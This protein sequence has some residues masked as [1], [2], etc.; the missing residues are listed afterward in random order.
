MRPFPWQG[1]AM[2]RP[3][4]WRDL[5]ELLIGLVAIALAV[6]IGVPV[7][8][9]VIMDGIR[10]VK[11]TRDSIV[12]TG[13]AKHPIEANLAEWRLTVSATAKTT[14]AAARALQ[15]KSAAVRELLRGGDLGANAV[16]ASPIAI[17]R[18]EIRE[19]TGVAKPAF[20]SVPAWV[21]YQDFEVSTRNIDALEQTAAALG[22][23]LLRGIDV[24]AGEIQYLS[25][26]LK[27][28]KYEALQK[29]VA[30]AKDRAETIADGLGGYLGAVRSVH[31]GV[32][33]ITPRNSTDVSNEGIND[34]S[35]REKDVNAVVNV[36]F[37]VER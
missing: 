35:S 28:A 15:P 9:A 1:P 12:V 37:T 34:V 16:T 24:S 2:E 19:P 6:G 29:A 14:A 30:D 7:T 4:T 23:L 5:P 22:G 18:T 17:E 11:N 27:V 20:R 3:R 21:V 25:T 26:E 10:D 8:A 32:Y 36:T 33:Q 13:S 31:L